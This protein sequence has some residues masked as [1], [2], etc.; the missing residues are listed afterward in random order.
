MNN[1]FVQLHNILGKRSS[2]MHKNGRQSVRQPR[3]NHTGTVRRAKQ[4]APHAVLSVGGLLLVYSPSG[5]SL[6]L[7]SSSSSAPLPK[8]Q[9][10]ASSSFAVSRREIM[11]SS[12]TKNAIMTIHFI[13]F[14]WTCHTSYFMIIIFNNVFIFTNRI[15]FFVS[16]FAF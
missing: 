2:K 1:E 15:I 8:I 6:S 12:L 14:K 11:F 10:R 7:F 3:R 5:V 13:C 4:K 9:P 16:A